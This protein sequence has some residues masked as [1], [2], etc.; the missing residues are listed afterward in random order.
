[1]TQP[2][3]V[4]LRDLRISFADGSDAVDLVD[5]V[6][7]ELSPGD[8]LGIVGESG[9]GKSL[10]ALAMM[11]LL[12]PSMT[13]IGRVVIGGSDLLNARERDMRRRR[14]RDIGM[15]FQDPFAALNPVFRVSTQLIAAVRAHRR[16]NRA[17][18]RSRAIELLHDVGLADH[19]RFLR[20]YPHQLSGGQAQR[21]SI[22]IALAG[23][24][25]VL[26]ADEPTTALDVTVQDGILAMLERLRA[27]R[28]LTLVFIS[29]DLAVVAR[30]CSRVA[31]MYAGQI[32]ESGATADVIRQPLHPYTRALLRC[33]PGLAGGAGRPRGIPGLPPQPG[34]RPRGCRFA[35][36]C[37]YSVASCHEPKPMM[38][39]GDRE[40]RCD[41]DTPRIFDTETERVGGAA[42]LARTTGA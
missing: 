36:R 25:A 23:D 39:R 19:E 35:D 34:E 1:M 24:P 21:I 16:C 4:E 9:S 18:A 10:T 38:R 14:G 31:V 33:A 32:V 22:A 3:A 37:G 27:E 30:L 41:R 13:T 17:E 28:H 5:G 42:P 6:N 7:L 40:V 8:A 11:R 2:A 12:P 20:R 29:H 26:L 15:V